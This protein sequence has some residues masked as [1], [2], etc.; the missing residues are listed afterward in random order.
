ACVSCAPSGAPPA[1][2]A[3]LRTIEPPTVGASEP[4]IVLRNLSSD[5][6]RVFFESSV[7]LLPRDT[8]GVQDVY[9]WE[10]QGVGSCQGSSESFSAASGGCLYLISSGRSPEAS[11]FADASANGNDV[12]FFTDQPLVGQDQDGAVDVY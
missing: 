5:G 12:F 7:A 2:P 6:G 8:N 3:T 11:F 1:G 9:E 10:Q 4:A